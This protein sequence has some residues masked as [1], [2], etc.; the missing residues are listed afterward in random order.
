MDWNSCIDGVRLEFLVQSADLVDCQRLRLVLHQILIR[1]WLAV[2]FA[3]IFQVRVDI[4]A[5]QHPGLRTGEGDGVWIYGQ[6]MINHIVGGASPVEG[7][8]CDAVTVAL[9]LIFIC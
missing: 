9:A 8:F 2:I 6:C 4:D 5:S 1:S 3:W 7:P